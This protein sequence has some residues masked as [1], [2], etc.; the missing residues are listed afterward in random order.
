MKLN[1]INCLLL[2]VVCFFNSPVLSA[3][4]DRCALDLL[5]SHRFS[6]MAKYIY[7]KFY[8]KSINSNW[9]KELYYKHLQVWSGCCGDGQILNLDGKIEA[10]KEKNNITE[11]VNSFNSLIDSIVMGGF[12]ENKSILFL[13][14]EGR[15]LDGEHRVGIALYNNLK[16]PCKNLN[17]SGKYHNYTSTFFK[18][19]GLDSKYLDAMALEYACLKKNS[20]IVTLF[21]K[22]RNKDD[23]V[24]A[25]LN[26]NGSIIYEKELNLRKNGPHNLIKMFYKGERWIGNW[27]N[28]FAGAKA[29]V[30][31]SFTIN[32]PAKNNMVVFLWESNTD[33]IVRVKAEIRSL[34]NIGNNSVHMNDFHYE[35]IEYAQT[36]FNENSIHFLN[37]A[38]P[39][40]FNKFLKLIDDYKK[41][42]IANNI[43]S[44][45]FC[46]DSSAIL[47]AYGIRDCNDLDLLHHGYDNELKS[48]GHSL[49]GSHNDELKYHQFGKDDII[50][51]PQNHFYFEGL[52]FASLGVLKKMKTKR[53]EEKDRRDVASIIKLTS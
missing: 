48:F 22:A 34:F 42:I 43:D 35:T 29:R 5:N 51:N 20:F 13:G 40:K 36:Y 52:K 47:S 38:T 8:Q 32:N 11:Y 39:K 44:D 23:V 28:N 45:C 33:D 26:A 14:T 10:R 37:Y 31:D 53:N 49:I 7:A 6:V 30:N 17:M 46:V 2:L 9:G 21:P 19:S 25:I 1:R 41:W 18:D 24:R 4:V 16:V 12:S 50:F 15:F 3:S 27:N